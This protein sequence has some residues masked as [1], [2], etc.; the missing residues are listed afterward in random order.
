MGGAVQ[1]Q[2]AS[3]LAAYFNASTARDFEEAVYEQNPNA[4]DTAMQRLAS[5]LQMMGSDE[6]EEILDAI[7]DAQKIYMQGDEEVE[8]DARAAGDR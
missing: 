4:I 1:E 5:P 7:K 3:L 6:A 2:V 8:A